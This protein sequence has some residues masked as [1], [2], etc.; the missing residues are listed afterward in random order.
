MSDTNREE[1]SKPISQ[2][3]V[4]I[5][6]CVIGGF[7]V[8]ST[9][10]VLMGKVGRAGVFTRPVEGLIE[11]VG[12]WSA[13]VFCLGLAVLGCLLFLRSEEAEVWRPLGIAAGIALGLSLFLGGFAP[14]QG[15]GLGSALPAALGGL[16]GKLSSAVIGALVL[17]V[18]AWWGVLS[19]L[20]APEKPRKFAGIERSDAA[21]S[22]DGVSA[23]EAALL[24]SEPQTTAAPLPAAGKR[25]PPGTRPITSDESS[26]TPATA[27][28]SADEPVGHAGEV[29]AAGSLVTHPESPAAE[30][31]GEDLAAAR[32][33]LDPNDGRGPAPGSDTAVLEPPAQDALVPTWESVSEARP[34]DP[35]SEAT[36]ESPGHPGP[37]GSTLEDPADSDELLDLVEAASGE[38]IE[39]VSGDGAPVGFPPTHA[40]WEQSVLFEGVEPEPPAPAVAKEEEPDEE[41]EEETEEPETVAEA[42]SGV[43]QESLFASDASAKVVEAEDVEDEEDEFEEEEDEDEEAE[44]AEAELEEGEDEEWEYVEEDEDEDEEEAVED[45]ELVASDAAETDKAGEDDEWEYVYEDEDEDEDEEDAAAS[46]EAE[47]QE[48]DE[49]EEEEEHVAASAESDAAEPEVVLQPLAA[50]IP[51]ADEE[52]AGDLEGVAEDPERLVYLSGLLILEQGR[53]A[54]S[55]LQRKFGIDF[56]RAC[57]VLDQLQ[58]RGLIGPYMGGTRREILL[59]REAWAEHAPS[60]T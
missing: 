21:D 23:A 38:V 33:D 17:L 60:A 30:S 50:P 40:P 27:D 53:V 47:A 45:G 9:V 49:A 4:G 18:T 51:V 34:Y 37:Q 29:H 2:D 12:P 43:R 55:M 56:D 7:F 31:P 52:L 57:I 54:V 5:V 25:L 59:T 32:A 10:Q 8:V 14:D 15:G 22:A 26:E 36:P 1:R 35:P 48:L 24:V 3:I 13:L 44:G 19:R 11:I 41:P 58:E 6:C 16:A 42:D 46:A 20:P 28:A 39:D